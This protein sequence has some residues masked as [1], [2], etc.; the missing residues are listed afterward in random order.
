M[1]NV[2]SGD[3]ITRIR[4]DWEDDDGTTI[5]NGSIMQQSRF[6]DGTDEE[7]AEACWHLVGASL[8]DSAIETH[9]LTALTR[10]LF[11]D[12]HVTTLVTVRA[13]L[14]RNLDTST[15]SLVVG[16]A[17]SNEWSEPFAADGDKIVVPPNSAF[18]ISNLNTGWTVDDSN[19]NLKLAASGGDVNYDIAIVG[20]LTASGSSSS[21]S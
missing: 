5:D 8:L 12:T 17:S 6:T 1:A 2:F 15:G 20:T 3:V 10:E 11:G 13:I 16:G 9:D 18:S 7:E 21:S 4:W 19:K 14:I